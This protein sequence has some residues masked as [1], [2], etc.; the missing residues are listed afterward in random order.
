VATP[1]E[2]GCVAF[3]ETVGPNA[4]LLK[5][6][7]EAAMCGL[8]AQIAGEIVAG[9]DLAQ[10]LT[11][12]GLIGGYRLIF[13][14]VRVGRGTPFFAEPRPALRLVAGNLIGRGRV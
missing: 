9:P 14:P 6:D 13:P 3:A 8:K 11:D 7:I 1:T 5:G 12:V 10:S 4:T 2:V